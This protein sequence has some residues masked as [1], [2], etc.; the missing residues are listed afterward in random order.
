[1]KRKKEKKETFFK[2]VLAVDVLA[3]SNDQFKT[4]AWFGEALVAVQPIHYSCKKLFFKG[5]RV[6]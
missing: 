2:T 6:K 3:R 4:L 1:M 5:K